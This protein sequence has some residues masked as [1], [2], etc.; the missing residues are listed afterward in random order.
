MSLPPTLVPELESLVGAEHVISD[1]EQVRVYDC[2]GLTGWRATPAAVV[3]PRSTGEV[4]AVVRA[5]ARDHVPFVA[6][7]AGTGLSGGALP[8]A[9]GIVIALT[10]MNDVLE[11]DLDSQRVV[12]QPGVTNLE[13]TAAVE[14]DGLF[15]A[16]DP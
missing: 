11:V 7:G 10:R 13:V 4:Q 15:Y 6:R 9:E 5:C 8:V 1:P 2:D 16:P 12:V 14:A 3:L